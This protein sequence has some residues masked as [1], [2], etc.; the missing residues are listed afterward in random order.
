VDA[1]REAAHDAEKLMQANWKRPWPKRKCPVVT[2][3]I[4]NRD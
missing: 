2:P 3:G 4:G 1:R